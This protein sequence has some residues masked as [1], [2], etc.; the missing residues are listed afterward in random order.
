[1]GILDLHTGQQATIIGEVTDWMKSQPAP[2]RIAWALSHMPGAHVVSSSFGVQSAVML[3]MMTQAK[4]DIP[5]LLMDTGYLFPETYRY[6]DAL[7]ERLSLNIHVY[8]AKISPAWQESKFGQLWEQGAEGL[9]KYNE[10]NKVEPM[11]RALTD[12]GAQT[13]FAGLRRVQ[14]ESRADVPFVQIKDG[15]VKVHPLADWSN[16]AVHKYMKKHDLPA[17]PLWEQGYVSVGDTHSTGKFKAGMR[18]EDTRFG[19]NGRECGLH[20]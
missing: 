10:M 7:K 3:H 12:L 1:M 11:A 15:R 9:K 4:P 16:R 14:A 13:W 8:G 2:S 19:G 17:H 20:T 5:V 18:E 6:I